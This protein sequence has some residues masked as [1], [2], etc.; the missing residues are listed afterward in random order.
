MPLLLCAS[1]AVIF[2]YSR[3]YKR[4]LVVR[5]CQAAPVVRCRWNSAFLPLCFSVATL[6]MDIINHADEGLVLSCMSIFMRVNAFSAFS[7]KTCAAAL[8]RWRFGHLHQCTMLFAFPRPVLFY[9]S[10][11]RMR[12]IVSMG[13]AKARFSHIRCRFP[14]VLGLAVPLVLRAVPCPWAV[15]L[16]A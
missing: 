14:S 6:M 3:R 13:R 16:Q 1:G 2:V 8:P 11:S 5:S 15:I 7:P 10:V 12:K 4:R 9:S